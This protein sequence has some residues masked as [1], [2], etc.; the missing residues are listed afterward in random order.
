MEFMRSPHII[1]PWYND[2]YT[3]EIEKVVV[4]DEHTLAVVATKAVPDLHL[5]LGLYP[6]AGPLLRGA[7]TK[8]WVRKY[9]WKVVPKHRALTRFP[10]SKKA[11]MSS[12]VEKTD[13]WAKDLRY[14]KNRFNVDLVIVNVVRDLQH[15][16][17]VFQESQVGHSSP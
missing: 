12:F 16:V 11:G 17:G 6:I 2:Y 5:K 4:F 3:R 10:I 8:D 14:F 1:A 9:N 15:H 7:G 13:W